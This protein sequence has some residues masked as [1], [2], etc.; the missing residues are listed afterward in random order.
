[1]SV[2]VLPIKITITMGMAN[3]GLFIGTSLLAGRTYRQ[4]DAGKYTV[5]SN[6]Y[7]QLSHDHTF[8]TRRFDK[9]SDHSGAMTSA[10]HCA[11]V[12]SG[13]VGNSHGTSEGDG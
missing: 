9:Y 4:P 5:S 10:P 7:P 11:H 3:N 2:R 13:G 1:M 8:R 6:W 12:R